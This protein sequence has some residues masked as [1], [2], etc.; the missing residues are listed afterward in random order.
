[1]LGGRK[2]AV[3]PD[4]LEV[5]SWNVMIGTRWRSRCFSSICT[6]KRCFFFV[7]FS[8]YFWKHQQVS[9]FC[10]FRFPFLSA[11]TFWKKHI[12]DK[13]DH[14]KRDYLRSYEQWT[15]KSKV[16]P[17]TSLGGL[18]VSQLCLQHL[19]DTKV[20]ILD[21][22]DV[23]DSKALEKLYSDWYW[24]CFPVLGGSGCMKWIT[25]TPWNG[26]ADWY[27]WAHSSLKWFCHYNY[28]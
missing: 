3:F 22:P 17:E 18:T 12:F 21:F 14:E 2:A 1:M 20:M 4:I 11:S 16:H 24:I 26:L 10:K 5:K 6:G 19:G 13:T 27:G 9:D 7:F 28:L 15:A 25:R 8:H 23:A